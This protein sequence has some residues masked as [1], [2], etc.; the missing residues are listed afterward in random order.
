[1]KKCFLFST[2]LTVLYVV[3]PTSS[4]SQDLEKAKCKESW[5]WGYIDKSSRDVVI[6]CEYS[7]AKNF[8][9][10]LAAVKKVF[11]DEYATSRWGFIDKTGENVI[12]FKFQEANSFSEGLAAVRINRKWGFIDNK[13]NEI[14]P[15]KYQDADDFYEGLAPVRLNGK[16]GFIDK[17]GTEV[18]PLK[19]KDVEYLSGNYALVQYNKFWGV[20][21][22]M[23]EVV[24]GMHEHLTSILPKLLPYLALTKK[25]YFCGR[26]S[27]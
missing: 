27:R 12:P 25:V 13:G 20:R 17:A 6:P 8:S 19:Y 15:Y 3:M 9:E 11:M 14:I 5:F 16:W 4:F 1:M 2:F 23:K 18:V 21:L 7:D 22:K 24:N 26:C 10:G